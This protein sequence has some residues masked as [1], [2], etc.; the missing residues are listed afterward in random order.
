MT[1]ARPTAAWRA[2]GCGVR[3]R[4]SWCGGHCLT[5]IVWRLLSLLAGYCLA[6]TQLSLKCLVTVQVCLLERTDART[7]RRSICRQE[8]LHDRH[9]RCATEQ[10][11][12]RH[13]VGT[14][15]ALLVRHLHDGGVDR[16]V[17]NEPE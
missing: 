15:V 2:G 14:G 8:R 9:R 16:A 13:D 10:L 6:D 4:P 5:V 12:R 7:Q 17:P 1:S 11:L 3:L